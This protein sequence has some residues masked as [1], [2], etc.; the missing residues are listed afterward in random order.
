MK[1]GLWITDN[2]ILVVHKWEK[3]IESD[4]KCLGIVDLR[5]QVWD[6]PHHW[7]SNKVGLKIDKLFQ[8]VKE[9]LLPQTGGKEGRHMKLLVT[10]DT[11]LPLQRGSMVTLNRIKK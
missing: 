6:L 2:Q 11:T 8:E 3:G 4:K 1:G 7:H 5:V 10:V 9:V